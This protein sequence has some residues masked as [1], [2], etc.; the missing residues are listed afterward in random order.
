MFAAISSSRFQARVELPP[1]RARKRK[2]ATLAKS[3]LKLAARANAL[4][5]PEHH[6]HASPPAR[7]PQLARTIQ[8]LDTTG[9]ALRRHVCNDSPSPADGLLRISEPAFRATVRLCA[10]RR[11]ECIS[12]DHQNPAPSSSPHE[13]LSA[14]GGNKSW[15]KLLTSPALLVL[16]AKRTSEGVALPQRARWSDGIAC[17]PAGGQREPSAGHTQV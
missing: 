13:T 12:R 7:R 1:L 5:F 9:K 3:V 11:A 15:K 16:L 8:R 2:S 4:P 14:W 17:P 6:H 10:T